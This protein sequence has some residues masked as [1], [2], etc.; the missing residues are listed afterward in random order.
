MTD[1]FHGVSFHSSQK[2]SQIMEGEVSR[3]CPQGSVFWESKRNF[4]LNNKL[5]K[6]T[7]RTK[8]PSSGKASKLSKDLLQKFWQIHTGLVSTLFCEGFTV[9]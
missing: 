4:S 1:S 3:Q 6:S 2:D 7:K 9:P 5:F 8:A